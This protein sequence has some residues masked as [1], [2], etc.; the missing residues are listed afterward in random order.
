M[1]VLIN[2]KICDNAK[3]CSGIAVCPTGAL[4]WELMTACYNL[5]IRVR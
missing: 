3:D 1:P 4:S 5:R 2:F